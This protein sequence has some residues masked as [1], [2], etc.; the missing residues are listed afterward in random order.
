MNMTTKASCDLAARTAMLLMT[1]ITCTTA[2]AQTASSADG[3]V[4]QKSTDGSRCILKEFAGNSYPREKVTFFPAIIDSAAVVSISLGVEPERFPN[5][6]TVYMYDH[7]EY[8]EMPSVRRNI[9][10]FEAPLKHIHV[11]DRSGTVVA[12]DAIPEHITIIPDGCFFACGKLEKLTLPEGLKV[13][14]NSA[15]TG[16]EALKDLIIPEGVTD[17]GMSAFFACK[18]LTN[19]T[20]PHSVKTIANRTFYECENLETITIPSSVTSIG[21]DAFTDCNH[22]TS[23]K[24]PVTDYSAFC[25]NKTL[26]C[27]YY[28]AGKPV[29]LINNDD[30][31]I[32]EYIVPEGVTS[33]GSSAF[34]NCTGLNTVTIAN[35]VTTIANRT[36][37]GCENLGNVTIPN[38]VTS[39]GEGA[40]HECR[41]FTCITIPTSV[42]AIGANAFF[43][44]SNLK[45][46][47]FD[48][49]K[50]QW[51]AVT[52]GTDWNENVHPDFKEH[53]RCT[54][55]FVTNN[56]SYSIPALTNLWSNQKV[57]K[58]AVN[59][60]ITGWYTDAACTNEWHFDTDLVPGDMTLYAKWADPC[61]V[62]ASTDAA[63]IEIPYGQEW[64]DISVTLNSLTLGW[65]Q[66]AGRS[67]READAVA[68][69]PYVG[70]GAYADF[71]FYDRVSTLTG[72]K[73][74]GTHTDGS[75]LSEP[76]TEAGQSGT[77]WVHI[78]QSTWESAAAGDYNGYLNY[79][80]VFISNDEPAETYDYSLGSEAQVTLHLI[81]PEAAPLTFLPNGGSGDAMATV[82]A[83]VGISTTLPA[84]TYGAPDGQSF[85]C[86]NT[87]ADGSGT[88]YYAGSELVPTGSMT[89]YA[90]WGNDYVIDLTATA[91]DASVSIPMG[92]SGQLIQLKGYFNYEEDMGLDLNLDGEKDLSLE[93][94]F[95]E[96]TEEMTASVKKLTS[97]TANYRFVLTPS[98]EEDEYGAVLIKFVAD[99][100]T[101]EQPVIE[102][103]YDGDMGAT[104]NGELLLSLSDGQPHNLMLYGR[105]L[106]RD[107]SWQ[108]LCLPFDLELEGSALEGATVM[109]LDTEGTSN[110]HQTGLE[111]ST[112]YLNFKAATS[113]A[114]GKP[115][116]VKWAGG[117]DIQN[118]VFLGITVTTQTTEI[119]NPFQYSSKDPATITVA[120]TANVTSLDGAVTFT[121]H[122]DPATLTAGDRGVLYLGSSGKLLSP[123]DADYCEPSFRAYLSVQPPI[124]LPQLTDVIVGKAATPA[125]DVN[126]DQRVSIADITSLIDFLTHGIRKVESNPE[127]TLE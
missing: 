25:E 84:C 111:G 90:E 56:T 81:I 78:P 26:D 103:L 80:A 17:I 23:V 51:D 20:I 33:I 98:G 38:S 37:S 79:V 118:P 53:W 88:R 73:G 16:C 44:C 95:D 64:T 29:Q 9:W 13:I 126:H 52:K 36:F 76:L 60:P 127:P 35:S 21:D 109:E 39:I 74:A 116:L 1:I 12:E 2:W 92:L 121:G 86:W 125:A 66:N 62:T 68:L 99:G 110:G 14:G 83:R 24:V 47:Y 69:T 113:I 30:V 91:L 120:A 106:H 70:S 93:Q 40:F 115:Y 117:S 63:F 27:I 4:I 108:T 22:L 107:G 114:A 32:T 87:E 6:E 65:F 112:L 124:T 49:P 105:T 96:A 48:A 5:L 11:I 61:A 85:L 43:G 46:I 18:A 54:V 10:S 104:Y 119:P 57:S 89:L 77:L 71:M 59:L 31:E 45:D 28:R 7:Y 123:A 97:L 50:A 8:H 3:W 34:R 100:P 19:I 41:A 72:Q 122:Y 94:E 82:N 102:L 15:F 55:T 58:P 101:V 42:T 75:R 67:V